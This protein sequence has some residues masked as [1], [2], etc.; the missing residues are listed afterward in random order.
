MCYFFIIYIF[1]PAPTTV[2]PCSS[3]KILSKLSNDPCWINP[4]LILPNN[5]SLSSKSKKGVLLG[6]LINSNADPKFL[7]VICFSTSDINKSDSTL[8]SDF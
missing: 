6:S 2:E 4:S 3:K 7:F 5:L 8:F 1:I